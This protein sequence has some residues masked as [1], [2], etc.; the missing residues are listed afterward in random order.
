MA[1]SERL[2]RTLG[3][4][5]V[6]TGGER[7]TCAFV[8]G[9]WRQAWWY[10]RPRRG[11]GWAGAGEHR[12]CSEEPPL[13]HGAALGSAGGTEDQRRWGEIRL[14]AHCDQ[15]S[16]FPR[17]DFGL[18]SLILHPIVLYT[19]SSYRLPPSQRWPPLRR[20]LMASTTPWRMVRLA[21]A[22]Q[23]FVSRAPHAAP[24][25][26]ESKPEAAES[27]NTGK[28]PSTLSTT[29]VLTIIQPRLRLQ[30]RA[31]RT[32]SSQT[33]K[34][35]YVHSLPQLKARPDN[36]AGDVGRPASR[37]KFAFVQRQD[38]RT[39]WPVSAECNVLR[40]NTS[41]ILMLCSHQDLLKGIYDMGFTKPSKIQERALPLLLRDP[42]VLHVS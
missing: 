28:S 15:I 31:R 11:P 26:S 42:Y 4:S 9:H 41:L 14:D 22:I 18:R 5:I 33:T 29:R 10:I 16:T 13:G 19:T 1:N 30:R 12:D 32:L 25:A 40:A 6:R 2:G 34:Y 23:V 7:S 21:M 17:C 35:Q 37:P 27:T 36:P 24:A 3:V 20:T 39:A 38:L 8:A